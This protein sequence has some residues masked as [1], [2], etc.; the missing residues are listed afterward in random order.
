[1]IQ[2]QPQK[3]ER[4]TTSTLCRLVVRLVLGACETPNSVACKGLAC[5][6]LFEDGIYHGSFLPGKDKSNNMLTRGDAPARDLGS[7]R[8]HEEQRKGGKV[9]KGLAIFFGLLIILSG[10]ESR[11]LRPI[12]IE[13]GRRDLEANQARG[14]SANR[15]LSRNGLL[16]N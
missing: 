16:R 13:T 1:V 10:V 14:W 6:G 7:L 2:A 15:K 4:R 11:R 12:R 5:F 3:V 9:G 8:I